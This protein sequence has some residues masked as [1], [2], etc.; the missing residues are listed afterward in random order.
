MDCRCLP[1]SLWDRLL[2]YET[3]VGAI[4]SQAQKILNEAGEH[5]PAA[6]ESLA[7]ETWLVESL[8]YA[9]EFVYDRTIRAAIQATEETGEDTVSVKISDDY[10][11]V[12]GHLARRRAVE[13]GYRLAGVVDF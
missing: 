2:P 7:P 12:A 11:K 5:G 13:A 6:A 8:E 1:Y 4:A 9:G 3:T 10:F